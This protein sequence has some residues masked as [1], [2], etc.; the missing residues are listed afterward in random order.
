[1]NDIKLLGNL[2]NELE[3]KS[4]KK[5]RPYSWFTIAVPRHNNHIEADYIRCVAFDQLATDL[6]SHCKKGRKLLVD[7]RL[8]VSQPNSP[9]DKNQI[10]YSVVA[11]QISFLK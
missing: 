8:E 7:G 6:V 1:M 9:E 5:E 10:F 3:L 2:T 11:R 4:T